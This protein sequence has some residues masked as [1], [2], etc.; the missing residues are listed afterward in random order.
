M[1]GSI[2]GFNV[3]AS[4]SVQQLAAKR[5]VPLHLHAVIYQLIHQLREELSARLPPLSSESVLGRCRD[6]PPVPRPLG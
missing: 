3:E 2:Y 1:P 4:R 6:P 5:G